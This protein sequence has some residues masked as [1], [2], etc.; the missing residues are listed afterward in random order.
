[1]TSR[2]KTW[3][4]STGYPIPL[5]GIAIRR[6]LPESVKEAVDGLIGRSVRYAFSHP[7]ASRPYIKQHAQEMADDVIDRHIGLYVNEY[8][9]NLGKK[10]REAVAF[11]LDKAAGLGII[12]KPVLPLIL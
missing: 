3:E 5:G 12:E 2:R 4:R 11:M 1:M 6:S 8:S 10:G 7:E 9:V